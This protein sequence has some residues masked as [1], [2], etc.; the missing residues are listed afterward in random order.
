[1]SILDDVLSRFRAAPAPAPAVEPERVS[2]HAA[3]D[4]IESALT[5]LGDPSRDPGAALRVRAREPL[6][7]AQ[8]DTW[9]EQSVYAGRAVE[10]LPR[11]AFRRGYRVRRDD[12]PDACA[13]VD[14][15]FGVTRQA[16][17]LAIL[18]RQYGGALA[19]S[20][21]DRGDLARP[22]LRGARTKRVQVYGWPE[23]SVLAWGRD[24]LDERYRLPTEYQISPTVGQAAVVHWSHTVY[25]GGFPLS[26]RRRYE[27]SGR[28]LPV[29][30]RYYDALMQRE[31]LDASASGLAQRA[32]VS[33]L[34][35]A[36]YVEKMSAGRATREQ[37][38]AR[39]Q[40]FAR[41]LS[42]VGVGVID[43]QDG[44]ERHPMSAGGWADLDATARRAIAAVES[45]PQAVWFG[46]T[47]S[48]LSSDDSQVRRGLQRAVS[49][50]QEVQITP[51]LL[52]LLSLVDPE[53]T[54]AEEIEWM[55]LDEPTPLDRAQVRQANAAAVATIAP[56]AGLT[57]D[58]IRAGMEGV[59]PDFV[60]VLSDG[61]S[62]DD[63]LAQLTGPGVEEDEPPAADE[64]AD[65]PAVDAD[66]YA[67]PESAR[68]NARK[69]LRWR[70]EHGDAVAGMTEVGWRRARQLATQARVG[71]ETVAKMAGFARHRQNAEVAAEYADE[72]WR[73][74]GYVAWLGWGGT[75]GIEWARE[76]TGASE[77]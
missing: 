32:S 48:G 62:F 63:L 13:E 12:E 7:Y 8:I 40:S 54:G 1:M 29:L 60:P 51:A 18:G 10:M 61:A 11:E 49:S 4:A 46:D 44:Y 6:S 57:A 28:D 53:W 16:L 36:G 3:S 77:E 45:I 41:A 26:E 35:L 2:R 30:E 21:P 67:V 68:N 34:R 20:I 14:A 75:S 64:P 59:D 24:A 65:E 76:I 43:A 58:E 27:R 23:V 38:L 37:V 71:R 74:A 31:V 56:L 9:I 66:T 5:G 19:V 22:R 55:D 42:S 50:Y 39:I 72:P 52:R 69:V 33:I 17:R 47:P 73:D 70:E 15:A 25:M